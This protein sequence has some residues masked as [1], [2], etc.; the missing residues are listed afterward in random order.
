MI[1]DTGEFIGESGRPIALS[2]ATVTKKIPQH[3]GSMIR[4]SEVLCSPR[5]LLDMFKIV[6]L[7][8]PKSLIRTPARHRLS[9]SLW[10]GSLLA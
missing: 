7:A 9:T 2:S 3:G 10:S 1:I 4:S 5:W 8:S 6:P